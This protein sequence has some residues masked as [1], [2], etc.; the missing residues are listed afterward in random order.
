MVLQVIKEYTYQMTKAILKK[1]HKK[2]HFT[3]QVD[4]NLKLITPSGYEF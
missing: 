3:G 1:K 4:K 2:A